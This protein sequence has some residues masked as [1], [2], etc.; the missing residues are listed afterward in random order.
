MIGALAAFALMAPYFGIV[1]AIIVMTVVSVFA[2]GRLKPLSV[3]VLAVTLSIIGVVIFHYML[4]TALA[5]FKWP[6]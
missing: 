1:P 2:D 3:L 4:G 6:L 5:L